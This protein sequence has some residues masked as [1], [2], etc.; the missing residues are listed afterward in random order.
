MCLKAKVLYVDTEQAFS[1]LERYL[2][3][4]SEE[5]QHKIS[6][7]HFDKDKIISLYAELLMRNEISHAL[8]TKFNEIEFAIY[9]HGK[10]YM[11]NTTN[12]HFS[13]SHSGNCISFIGYDSPI[14]IDVE[15]ISTG[16]LDIAKRFF[17]DNEFH[18]IN[19][20]ND[21]TS[22][23]YEIWT[24]KEAYVK[25]LGL[26]LSKSFQSFDVINKSLECSFLTKKL[27][28][29]MLTVC[30]ELDIN[31]IIIDEVDSSELINISNRYL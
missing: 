10:P 11:K 25:L 24:A 16:N 5:R 14:G 29:Y 4:I 12:Y 30:L 8:N 15:Q 17:T 28:E 3:L 1:N 7:F 18:Y 19:S 26:G 20:S 9:E 27:T 31:D 23:F 6:R 2:P 21:S 13:L 22:A